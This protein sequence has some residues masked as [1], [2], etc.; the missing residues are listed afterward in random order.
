MEE[1]INQ[2]FGQHAWQI[3]GAGLPWS[4]IAIIGVKMKFL[5]SDMKWSDFK[6]KYWLNEN[7]LDILKGILW[8]MLIMRLG[9]VAIHLIEKHAA[10]D[11][12][13]TTDFVIVMIVI[14]GFIQYRLHKNRTPISKKMEEKRIDEV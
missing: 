7:G 11:V 3:W 1:F 12:P 4:L 13:E 14:S 10:F 6:V 2:V 5:P 9:D 8:A